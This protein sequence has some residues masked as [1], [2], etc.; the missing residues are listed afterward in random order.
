M[1]F[2]QKLNDML[3]H[4]DGETITN[5]YRE[6][7]KYF[8]LNSPLIGGTIAY[9]DEKMINDNINI[10]SSYYDNMFYFRNKFK[11]LIALGANKEEELIKLFDPKFM[12]LA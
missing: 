7:I 9:M 2:S 8:S 11:K 12:V 3:W 6:N 5:H 1:I 4:L 10:E